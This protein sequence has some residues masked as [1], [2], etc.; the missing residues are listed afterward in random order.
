MFNQELARVL[1]VLG[2]G[3]SGLCKA[4]HRFRQICFLAM[5][6]KRG[7]YLLI[8]TDSRSHHRFFDD[9]RAWCGRLGAVDRKND[10]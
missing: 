6:R 4:V 5:R 3:D 1:R 10:V 9:K 7:C 2:A 8:R